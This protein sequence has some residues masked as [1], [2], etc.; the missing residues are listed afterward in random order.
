MARRAP[1]PD[2]PPDD[3]PD[4]TALRATRTVLDDLFGS[5]AERTFA[6]RL[7]DGRVEL[8]D[9]ATAPFTLVLRRP[10]A[11]RRMLLP[12]TELSIVEAYLFG[13]IDVEGDLEAAA[14]LGD[15][16]ARHVGSTGALLALGRH[17]LAL[18]DDDA[19][20][21]AASDS[22]PDERPGGVARVR[23]A[24]RLWR[25]GRAHTPERDR[26]AV[27]HHYD[28]GNDFYAL[29]L[30]Q[31][32][33]Y[34][35]A[36]FEPGTDDLDAAQVAKLDLVCRKLRLAPGERLLDIGC[37]WGALVRHAA[38]HYGVEAVGITL[39]E[40]QAALARERIAAAG[41]SE[42]CSVQVID[43]RALRDERGFDK[44]SSVGMVEHVGLARLPDYFA[45]AH[46][47]LRPR[48]LFLNH[49]IVGIAAARPSTLRDRALGR[50]WRRNAFIHTYVFPDG[51]LVPVASMIAAAEGAGFETRDMES[52]REHYTRTLRH[53]VA[54]LE[55]RERD[56][57]ALVGESTYRVWRLYMAAAAYGF[58][59]GRIGLV[60]TLL[61]KPD[62]RGVVDIPPTRDD[63]YS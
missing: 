26:T 9:R 4:T 39:S 20:S 43:Y 21:D 7:W 5:R 3:A 18:P 11:L 29:W 56:A 61:A 38:T 59:S 15:V 60:Q 53:W 36:Y 57:V 22:L 24:R 47:L 58:R 2:A 40:P 30:D 25:V 6:V 10:G 46:R 32:M 23:A 19:T 42:R 63:L 41:L 37:G 13:D 31:R 14:D 34:S 49:G 51:D 44:I 8:P 62:D 12:L 16:I 17:V 28:V 54:R 48:G 1:A 45:A 55:R 35:C 52:L 50:L 27:R 33:V